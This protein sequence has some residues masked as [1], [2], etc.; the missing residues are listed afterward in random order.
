MKIINRYIIREFLSPFMYSLLSFISIFM[1]VDL[2]DTLDETLTHNVHILTL[3]KY[4]LLLT[5]YIL[6][7]VIPITVLLASFYSIK[8][9]NKHN[10]IIAI[11]MSG[12][13]LFKLLK[14]FLKLGILISLIVLIINETLVPQTLYRADTLRKT[15]MRDQSPQKK[16]KQKNIENLGFHGKDNRLYYIGKFDVNKKEI[17]NIL[18]FKYNNENILKQRISA[19]SGTW[20]ENS[21]LFK[22]VIVSTYTSSESFPQQKIFK[23]RIFNIDITPETLGKNKN[24]TE[25]MNS[26]DLYQL[27]YKFSQEDSKIRNKFIVDLCYKTA[28]PFTSLMILLFS[29]PLALLRSR[30]G[31]LMSIGASILIGIIFYAVMS[32]S[33]AF[34][35]GGIFP[36]LISA[37]FANIL[38]GG[39]GICLTIAIHK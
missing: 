29:L 25:Y 39:F 22:D 2:F 13:S 10:E 11:R 8:N 32:I 12:V 17:Q 1:I 37:W 38:F 16:T 23:E 36:P 28:F 27:I 30:S 6:V 21:W 33:I 5:P 24:Q 18:I 20:E 34:G 3:G 35:K 14:P 7:N 4:Y 15:K 26:Y 31:A 9:F 19:L